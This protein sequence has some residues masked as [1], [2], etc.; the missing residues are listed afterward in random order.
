[1][2]VIFAV[3]NMLLLLGVTSDAFAVDPPATLVLIHGRIHTQDARR[4]IAQ[5]MARNGNTIVAVGLEQ[6]VLS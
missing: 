4:T 3:V 6:D 5:A 1:M 2:K